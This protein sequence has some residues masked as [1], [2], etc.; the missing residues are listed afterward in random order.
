M[1]SIN[2]NALSTRLQVMGVISLFGAPVAQEDHVFRIEIGHGPG[3]FLYEP[4]VI[5]RLWSLKHPQPLKVDQVIAVEG[6]DGEPGMGAR[7][8][9][10]VIVKENSAELLRRFPLDELTPATFLYRRP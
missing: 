3:L 7:I 4:S 5:N 8:D 9:D 10:M 1:K 6:R 2:M